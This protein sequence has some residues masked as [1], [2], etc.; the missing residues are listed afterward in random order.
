MISEDYILLLY[1]W[2]NNNSTFPL[3]IIP[4]QESTT[5]IFYNC[6]DSRPSIRMIIFEGIPQELH[7][8]SSEKTKLLTLYLIK[9]Q[10]EFSLVVIT[11]ENDCL[12]LRAY[13]KT[14]LL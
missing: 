3:F 7:E 9:I 5:L 4:Y 11:R 2:K 8:T 12:I 14:I 1:W 13:P 10:R 6:L